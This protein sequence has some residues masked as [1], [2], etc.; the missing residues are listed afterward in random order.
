MEPWVDFTLPSKINFESGGLEQVASRIKHSA[1]RYLLVSVR[2]DQVDPEVVH[3]LMDS[4]QK[5]SIGVLLYDDLKGSPDTEQIDSA[6]YFAKKA[7][8]DG[9]IA[10]GSLESFNGAKA[11]ALLSNNSV[12]AENLFTYEPTL[13]N[14]ALPLFV[15]PHEPSM[16]EELLPGFSMVDP[17]SKQRLYFSYESLFPQA[18]FYDPLISSHVGEVRSAKLVAASLAYAAELAISP[19]NN[20]L[21]SDFLFSTIENI[22]AVGLSFYQ[23]SAEQKYLTSFFWNSAKLGISMSKLGMGPA[24]AMAQSMYTE[25][26]VDFHYAMAIMLP[27]VMEYFLT[28]SPSRLVSIAKSLGEDTKELSVIEASIKAVEAIRKMNM[29]LKIPETLTDLEIPQEKFSL[30]AQNAALLPQINNAPKKLSSYEME[31]ILL[32]A[33]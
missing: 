14:P 20:A 29:E 28:T 9:V 5:N 30:I 24:W 10:L 8:I 27:H 17:R 12:F 23:D 15:I 7:H 18:V 22:K 6:T 13:K 19:Y 16:G 33:V 1:S 4:L 25:T 3:R 31:S 26:K 11:I 32:A 2:D 21:T